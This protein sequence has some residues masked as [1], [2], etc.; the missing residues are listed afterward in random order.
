[1]AAVIEAI[2]RSFRKERDIGKKITE[3]YAMSYG[4]GTNA[5]IGFQPSCY[6]NG[7]AWT[8]QTA[9][10]ALASGYATS[11][12][13]GDPVS[14]SSNGVVVSG[15]NGQGAILGIFWGVKYIDSFGN[16]QFVPFWA[17]STATLN[18]ANA[19]ALII[20]DMNVLY[21]VSLN[22]STAAQ[23]WVFQTDI[24]RNANFVIAAG[25]TAS[26]NSATYLDIHTLASTA[27]LPFKLVRFTPVP[28]QSNFPGFQTQGGNPATGNYPNLLVSINNGIY[29]GGTGTQGTH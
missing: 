19:E 26:G 9:P 24:G 17:A 8:G 10:Y 4:N 18:S 27:T 1:M 20:D 16:N 5:P 6:A 11:I 23:F 3:V 2:I 29:K 12:F 14:L 13:R 7:A 15:A 28:L 25:S 21:D 22:D